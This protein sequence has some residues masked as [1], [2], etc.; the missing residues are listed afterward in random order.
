MKRFINKIFNRLRYYK[1]SQLSI[2][3]NCGLCGK[4]IN[5]IMEKDWTWGICE[6]CIN[7]K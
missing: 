4:R 2:G 1:I 3:G 5:E 7:S 6:D